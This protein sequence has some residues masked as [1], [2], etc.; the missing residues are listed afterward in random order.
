MRWYLY[1]LKSKRQFCINFASDSSCSA[2]YDVEINKQILQNFG[3]KLQTIGDKVQLVGEINNDLASKVPVKALSS[4][5][6]ESNVNQIKKVLIKQE[7]RTDKEY[8][9]MYQDDPDGLTLDDMRWIDTNVSEVLE[10]TEENE[11]DVVNLY[12]GGDWSKYR[13]NLIS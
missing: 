11:Q 8:Q 7:I 3:L 2:C 12:F 4:S 9:R 1:E 10:V 5:K 6:D 13:M